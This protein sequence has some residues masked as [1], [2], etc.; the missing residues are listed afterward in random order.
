MSACTSLGSCQIVDGFIQFSLK[1]PKLTLIFVQQ[2]LLNENQC[3]RLGHKE[4]LSQR[5][6]TARCIL[7]VYRLIFRLSDSMPR[8]R[9][10]RLRYPSRTPLDP[11]CIPHS[12]RRERYRCVRLLSKVRQMDRSYSVN[13]GLS[14][15]LCI[16][17]LFFLPF[18]AIYKPWNQLVIR[19]QTSISLKLVITIKTRVEHKKRQ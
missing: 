19:L 7:P 12:E 1:F 9:T 15:T 8:C 11:S 10:K 16:C 13:V 18:N 14:Q 3:Q 17:C 6:V 5:L 2:S 4:L